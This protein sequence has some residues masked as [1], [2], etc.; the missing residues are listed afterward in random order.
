MSLVALKLSVR[1]DQRIFVIETS[2]VADVH[3][4]VLH[5][6]DPAATVR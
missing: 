5:A 1:I 6:V 2:D 4:I 3:D